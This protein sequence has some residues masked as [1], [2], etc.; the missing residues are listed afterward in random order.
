M[1][2]SFC[3]HSG[4]RKAWN[5]PF[6]PQRIEERQS[7][8]TCRINVLWALKHRNSH[9]S[10]Q[11]CQFLFVKTRRVNPP[12]SVYWLAKISRFRYH[13]ETSQPHL[14]LD[15]SPIVPNFLKLYSRRYRI[16][17]PRFRGMQVK[18]DAVPQWADQSSAPQNQYVPISRILVPWKAQQQWAGWTRQI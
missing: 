15:D 11:N 13:Q 5:S 7:Q 12:G 2:Y 8:E 3:V 17:N 4:L 6:L 9:N 1:Q 18:Y 10:Q 16:Q 14:E